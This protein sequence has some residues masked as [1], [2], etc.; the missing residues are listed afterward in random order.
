MF[1]IVFA[2]IPMFGDAVGRYL[3]ILIDRGR[4]WFYERKKDDSTKVEWEKSALGER[5][6]REPDSGS[7]NEGQDIQP[8][9]VGRS[10]SNGRRV[11]KSRP[12]DISQENEGGAGIND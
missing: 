5:G 7:K 11:R 12:A 1:S 9:Y 10:F 3:G 4:I 2:A 8:T 6:D